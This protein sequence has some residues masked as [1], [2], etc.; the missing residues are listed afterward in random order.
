MERH[1]REILIYWPPAVAVA[2][3]VLGRPVGILL[4]GPGHLPGD[5]IGLFVALAASPILALI[6]IVA[7]VREPPRD[8]AAAAR[9]RRSLIAVCVIDALLVLAPVGVF[10]LAKLT[11]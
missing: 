4:F 1:V 7:I 6:S 9:S 3:L 5:V 2:A 10:L 11:P 8:R